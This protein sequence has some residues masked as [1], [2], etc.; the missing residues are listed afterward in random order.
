MNTT[1][2]ITLDA[3]EVEAIKR[4]LDSGDV[5]TLTVTL[6][7]VLSKSNVNRRTIVRS[8][9]GCTDTVTFEPV[10]AYDICSDVTLAEY[11]GGV[12]KSIIYN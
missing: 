7:W 6:D 1:H 2:N 10:D 9:P 3:S 8:G 11:F 4:A 12:R 5:A